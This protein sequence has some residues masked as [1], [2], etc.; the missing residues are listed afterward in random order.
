MSGVAIAWY[1]LAHNSPLIAV[2]PAN[3]VFIGD[4]PLKTTLPA[5]S[6]SQISSVQRNVVGMAEVNY[7]VVDR[8][9]V[10]I[11][12]KTYPQGD[13]I[14]ALIRTA[15]PVSHGT[16]NG[17]ACEAILPDME[18]PDMYDDVALNYMQSQDYMVR[19]TR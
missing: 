1:L 6:V 19:F 16:V 15:L 12:T 18:G 10:T 5:I 14:Q 7:S 4:I 8:V 11:L 2:V 3:R 9:Q 13:S 17:F